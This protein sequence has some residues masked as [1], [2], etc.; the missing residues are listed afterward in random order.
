MEVDGVKDLR[1]V[2]YSIMP[3]R[4]DAGALAMAIAA[5]GGRGTLVGANLSHFGVVRAKLEQMGVAKVFTPGATTGEIVG[6]V[7]ETLGG[8]PAA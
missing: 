4:L 1:A 3:D 6:W 2:E 5:T 8:S 7:R